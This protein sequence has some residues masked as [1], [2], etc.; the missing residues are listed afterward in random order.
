MK[1]RIPDNIDDIFRDKFSEF[2]SEPFSD[3]KEKIFTDFYSE[4]SKN[5]H[6]KRI[7]L[8]GL[9][10]KTA[11]YK[12]VL[13]ACI[14]G[15]VIISAVFFLIGNEVPQ[16][17]VSIHNN[18]SRL[19]QTGK[20]SEDNLH[21]GNTENTADN[22]KEEKK[23]PNII[24]GAEPVIKKQY[25]LTKHKTAK[26]RLVLY[27]PD[28]S[29]L[30]LNR[31]SELSYMENFEDGNRMV[32][33]SGEVY[34]DVKKMKNR[35]FV[36]Y[37]KNGRI[38]VLGTSFS[39]KSVPDGREEVIVESGKVLF[40]ERSNPEKNKLILTPGMKGCL[41][42]GKP[43]TSTSA[44]HPNDLSWKTR[45]LVFNKTPMKEV[46]KEVEACFDIRIKMKNPKVYNCN[47]SSKFDQS[48]SLEEILQTLAL[49]LSGSYK[50]KNNEYIFTSKG[51]N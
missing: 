31:Y 41:E 50:F 34:F 19:D 4:E 36:V 48:A 12:Y 43:M 8:S 24:I 33:M 38:E 39:I 28:S 15:I 1:K 10:Q 42:P 29:K 23:S 49:S 3:T 14:S 6:G 40:S 17:Q 13:A 32:N 7:F 51:C 5:K 46:I 20:T 27:L 44:D 21:K 35:P 16:N 26:E 47:F 18:P 22:M 37:T 2:E 25:R 9:K 45:K 11:E 30:Y